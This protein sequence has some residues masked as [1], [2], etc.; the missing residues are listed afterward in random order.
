VGVK[1]LLPAATTALA[2]AFVVVGALIRLGEV[3]GTRSIPPTKPGALAPGLC[4][5]SRGAVPRGSGAA[6]RG[7]CVATAVIG[8]R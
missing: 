5:L 3:I 4:L 7:L 6:V 1:L 2:I 8:F